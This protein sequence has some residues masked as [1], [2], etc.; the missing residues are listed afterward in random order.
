MIRTTRWT[1]S[2]RRELQI[3][4]VVL[5]LPVKVS[6]PIFEEPGSFFL[7]NLFF[8]KL[9][10]LLGAAA[11]P[12]NFS[13]RVRLRSKW[14][15]C[16]GRSMLLV[17]WNEELKCEQ[18]GSKSIYASQDNCASAEELA[19][20]IRMSQRQNV[21]L[22][23]VALLETKSNVSLMSNVIHRTSVLTSIQNAVQDFWTDVQVNRMTSRAPWRA[24]G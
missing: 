10:F 12:G 4:E 13:N 18:V 19:S 20:E 16:D 15:L 5:S 14:N 22:S 8:Q 11:S 23:T 24:I 21:T 9:D 2:A 7:P 1:R 3:L 6:R 17:V